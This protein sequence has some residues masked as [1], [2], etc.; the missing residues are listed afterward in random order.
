MLTAPEPAPGTTALITEP[1][2]ALL[3]DLL[4]LPTTGPLEGGTPRLWEAQKRYAAAAAP[5]GFDTVRHGP[6]DRAW[7]ELPDVPRPVRDAA[8]DPG[9]LAEQP[10]LLLRLGPA[11]APRERTVMFNVHLDT[12]AGLQPVRHDPG[13]DTFHGRGAVDAKGPAV[14]LLAGLRAAL[15]ARPGLA[16][17]T[18]VLLQAVAG[19]EGGALGTIGTRP[20]VAAGHFGRL[21]VFCEPTGNRAL[22]R[23]TAAM[24]A[25]ITTD[26]Q[27]AVDDRPSAGHNATVLLGFLAQHL[28]GAV[29]PGEGRLCIAGLHTGHLHNRVY[30]KGELL[31]NLAYPDLATAA[32]L[33]QAV[34]EALADGLRAF[35]DRFAANPLL[36]RTAVD[37]AR[38]TR[39]DWLKR[40]LPALR[41]AA[42]DGWLTG[43]LE[44]A[45]IAGWPDG[46]P[47]FTCDAIWLAGHPGTATAVLGPGTLAGNHAHADGE[48]VRTAELNGFA[49]AVRDLL[50]AFDADHSPGPL[51]AHLPTQEARA[52]CR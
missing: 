20:L 43:L 21:N 7:V 44:R 22:T 12:V 10:S 41:P 18:T 14:A 16:A 32:R 49:R 45:G 25:R 42:G 52:A 47:G 33:E 51:S 2:R 5:L 46:E 27:D 37:A 50:C 28:A 36:A 11:G 48:F 23:C 13:T 39:L 30:G 8:D 4:A 1:D 6:P 29:A 35:A 38:I 40:G 34:T 17:R 3:L 15:A 19:E 26:G 31:I 9:F 24:T